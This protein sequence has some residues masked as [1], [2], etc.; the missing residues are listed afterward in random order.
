MRSWTRWVIIALTV[1][2]VGCMLAGIAF[3]VGAFVV[4]GADQQ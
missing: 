1:L 3:I 2:A 4:I